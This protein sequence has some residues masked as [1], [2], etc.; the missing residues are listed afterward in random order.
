[1]PAAGAS[2]K[3]TSGYVC[4]PAEFFNSLLGDFVRHPKKR[5]LQQNLPLAE[6]RWML[7]MTSPRALIIP[8][9]DPGKPILDGWSMQQLFC[10]FDGTTFLIR[11]V[12]SP[13]QVYYRGR[14]S[15]ILSLVDVIFPAGPLQFVLAPRPPEGCVAN[16][17]LLNGGE[18][19]MKNQRPAHPRTRPRSFPTH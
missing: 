12:G 1:L 4:E 17:E 18:I 14:I 3:W 11:A 6:M 7:T 9:E 5:L 10:S 2:S 13:V 8:V 19:V 15:F 16:L